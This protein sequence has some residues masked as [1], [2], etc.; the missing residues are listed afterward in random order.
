MSEGYRFGCKLYQVVG[1]FMGHT[2]KSFLV[3]ELRPSAALLALIYLCGRMLI[4]LWV[5]PYLLF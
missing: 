5:I 3:Q 1:M 4:V 2:I